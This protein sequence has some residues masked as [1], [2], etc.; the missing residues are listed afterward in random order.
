MAD[1]LPKSEAAEAVE[2]EYPQIPLLNDRAS[3]KIWELFE[4]EDALLTAYRDL[5]DKHDFFLSEHL[6]LLSTY[7][8]GEA[9][10]KKC[11][12]LAIDKGDPQ[13]AEKHFDNLMRMQREHLAT[14]NSFIKLQEKDFH[15]VVKAKRKNKSAAPGQVVGAPTVVKQSA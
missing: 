11:I 12:Q 5:N 15:E 1:E 2:R 6:S 4:K 10:A 13:G 14:L 3:K 9:Q 7:K 8:D